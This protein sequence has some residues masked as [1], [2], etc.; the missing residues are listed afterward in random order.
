[1]PFPSITPK[2]RKTL[3]ASSLGNILEWYDFALF[4]F[5]APILA[6]LFFPSD[7]HLA[8]LLSTFGVFAAGFLMR[9]LGGA[10][11]GHFGDKVGRKNA[12]AASVILMAIPTTLLGL[13]PTH[14]Q[15]GLLAP[16]LLTVLRLIQGLS[17]GGEL[18]GSIS[19]IVEHSPPSQRGF[20]GSWASNSIGMGLL[21]GSATGALMTSLL[22]PDDLASWGWRIPFL[23]GIVVGGVG[24]YLRMKLEEPESFQKLQQAG[25]MSPRASPR[26]PDHSLA[27]DYL[28]R[29][30][31]L[32]PGRWVLH[33]FCVSHHLSLK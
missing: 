19:F 29:I 26:S 30:G 21:L 18:T 7:D 5:F 27:S 11:F 24:L 23:F 33:D 31:H 28:N 1:M 3:V 15:V 6:Q 17:V 25:A 4:G 2:Q 13:L 12:L 32:D 8:S 22:S 16:I 9:P 20:F 14:S 10:L